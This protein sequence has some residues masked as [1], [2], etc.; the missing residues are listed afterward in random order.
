MGSTPT[1]GP[2]VMSKNIFA[3]YPDIEWH[4]PCHSS[5]MNDGPDNFLAGV[6]GVYNAQ[7]HLLSRYSN[8]LSIDNDEGDYWACRVLQALHILTSQGRE[9]ICR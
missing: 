3:I 4:E 2:K 9:E 1:S 6:R 7:G 5:R 8:H